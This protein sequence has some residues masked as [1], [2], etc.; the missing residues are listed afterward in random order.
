[1]AP[2]ETL[3]RSGKV[4]PFDFA[5]LERKIATATLQVFRDVARAY[6]DESV[7][8]RRVDAS[9]WPITRARFRSMA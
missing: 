9:S 4:V 8:A 3:E 7:C 6:P 5:A 2:P 1:M